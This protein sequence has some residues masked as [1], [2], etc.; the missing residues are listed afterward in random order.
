M[1]A[2]WTSFIDLNSE[3]LLI[4]GDFLALADL[5][6]LLHVD[7]LSLTVALVARLSALRVHAWSHLPEDSSH[8]LALASRASL[9]S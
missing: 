1:L 3:L 6:S 7:I 2:I 9:N 8:T 4:S 5:A